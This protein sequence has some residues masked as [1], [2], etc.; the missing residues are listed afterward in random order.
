MKTTLDIQHTGTLGD[1]DR[2]RM[3]FDADS[4]T[5][6]MGILTDLYSNKPAA[7]VREYTTNALDSHVAAGNPAPVEIIRPSNL[8]PTLVIRDFGVGLSVD[9]IKTEYSKYGFSSKRETNDQV[10]MLG[11]GCKSGLTY[12][13]QFTITARQNGREAVVLV[14]RDADGCGVVQIINESSTTEPNGV[15][16]SIPV[17]GVY[18]MNN[19]I[20]RFARFVD[21]GRLLVNGTP[22]R[23]VWEDER[24]RRFDED[25]L[26]S[27]CRENFI[28]MGGVAY[29]VND[30]HLPIRGSSRYYTRSGAGIIARV[31]IGSVKPTPSREALHYTKQTKET[32]GM[33][34][35]YVHAS[36]G[37]VAWTDVASAAT[38]DEAL[39][40]ATAWRPALDALGR[41]KALEWRGT[42]VP[43]NGK[44]SISGTEQMIFLRRGCTY[45]ERVA[46]V[47]LSPGDDV[48]LV[49]GFTGP[50]I[51]DSLKRR[52]NVWRDK[53][54]ADETYRAC[55][56]YSGDR[57]PVPWWDD[58]RTVTYEELRQIELPKAAPKV[59]GPR[60]WTV[61]G[62]SGYLDERELTPEEEKGRIFLWTTDDPDL[63]DT[64]VRSLLDGVIVRVPK[65]SLSVFQ[66]QYP[67]AEPVIQA[68][69]A[70]ADKIAA[71]FAPAELFVG[72]SSATYGRRSWIGGWGEVME[73]K[74]VLD[75]DLRTLLVAYKGVVGRVNLI[76]HWNILLEETSLPSLSKRVQMDIGWKS[77]VTRY[78]FLSRCSPQYGLATSERTHIT[79]Y[80]NGV[81]LL[82]RR[83]AARIAKMGL[84]GRR[85]RIRPF[86]HRKRAKQLAIMRE[87]ARDKR[88]AYQLAHTRAQ[89]VASRLLAAKARQEDKNRKERARALQGVADTMTKTLAAPVQI[90]NQQILTKTLT[91]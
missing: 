50:K 71:Q 23:T 90:V 34:H 68:I 69:N 85:Q 89:R 55:Y 1:A 83:R 30:D 49:T 63:R 32:L 39:I 47:P 75:P 17:R 66:Q 57:L 62:R 3:E 91:P 46:S 48:V 54:P 36:I 79:E 37:R 88:S 51:Y 65:R 76:A 26:L 53:Q 5:Q 8:N 25:V 60:R 45:A 73:P 40:R 87:A 18:E 11:L 61:L 41:S 38:A 2:T 10:G 24:Y 59:A 20:D 64:S 80:V 58:V 12:T 77:V 16:V 67:Q 15:E 74:R 4:V 7:V 81:Y 29:P 9:Q 56:F 44:Y 6:L 13:S 78:P 86:A 70:E 22:F 35:D 31:P 72:T 82:R 21:P 19:E 84:R 28:V 14:T 27:D 42:A 52:L 43:T 33:L